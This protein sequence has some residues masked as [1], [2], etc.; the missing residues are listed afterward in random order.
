MGPV[1][2]VEVLDHRGRV[3]RRQ[4]YDTF[5]VH[6]GRAYTNEV[7]LDDR[8]VCPAHAR[9]DLREDGAL[10]IEDLGSVNGM[11]LPGARSRVV[12]VPVA[13]G[14]TVRLGRAAVRVCT[15]DHPVPPAL[16]EADASLTRIVEGMSTGGVL[17]VIAAAMAVLV[18]DFGVSTTDASAVTSTL[19][20]AFGVTIGLGFWAAAWAT[21]GR[22]AGRRFRYLKHLAWVAGGAAGL[23]V[24]ARVS[25]YTDFVFPNADGL[26]AIIG[27]AGAALAGTILYGHFAI[28][29]V[30]RRRTRLIT[31]GAVAVAA[32]AA[33]EA[34]PD[35]PD[36]G[37]FTDLTVT[38]TIEPLPRW[39]VPTTDLA[40]FL[41]E[42]G[43]ARRAVD[44]LAEEDAPSALPPRPGEEGEDLP[45]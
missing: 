25:R 28:A 29:D 31:V 13:T 44:R 19:E 3:A 39:M 24:L 15:P 4:R 43:A 12:T 37:T 9:I 42:A 10:Q 32:F 41:E 33:S 6:L 45:Q 26:A 2:F 38:Y 20:F 35:D 23:A 14:V 22:L 16:R 30:M 1:I 11:R 18:A 36:E 34:I 40:D 5:P 17:G 27:I 8:T 7:I 21:I